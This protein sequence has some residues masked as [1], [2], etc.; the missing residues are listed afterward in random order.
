MLLSFFWIVKWVN[1]REVLNEHMCIYMDFIQT[2]IMSLQNL[3][4]ICLVFHT[5][6]KSGLW[7]IQTTTN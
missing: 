4:Q 5:V 2:S 3:I 6:C 7:A 1:E